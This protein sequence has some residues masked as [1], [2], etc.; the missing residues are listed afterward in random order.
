ML[1]RRLLLVENHECRAV[2]DLSLFVTGPCNDMVVDSSGRAYVGN[3]GYDVHAG[4]L[5]QKACIICVDAMRRV[6]CAAKELAFPN[7]MVISPDGNT[8]VVAETHSQRLTAFDIDSEGGLSHRRVF[9]QFESC[10]PDGICM[11][12]K[13]AI[14]VADSRGHRVVR[15][16]AG[17]SIE[18]T[19]STGDQTAYA[20][21]LGGSD[22]RTLFICTS[23][24]KGPT[25][26]SKRDGRIEFVRVE[27]AGAGL[28]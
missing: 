25:M 13:G 10:F 8:L 27:T 15:V 4:E 3:F 18:S 7:G 28:P 21:M 26:A 5:P 2:A 22:R 19:V 14:W 9:A 1:D 20:C 17:G 23:S 11:D 16:V 12:E 24:G 6:T